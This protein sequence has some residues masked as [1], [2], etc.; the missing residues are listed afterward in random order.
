MNARHSSNKGGVEGGKEV[1][2][3]RRCNYSPRT[4]DHRFH[5]NKRLLRLPAEDGPLSAVGGEGTIVEIEISTRA[6]G[7]AWEKKAGGIVCGQVTGGRF[8]PYIVTYLS[9]QRYMGK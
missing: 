1:K 5:V 8:C 3:E 4:Q 6:H 7:Y 9:V 2:D